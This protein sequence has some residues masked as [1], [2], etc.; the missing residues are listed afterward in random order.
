MS[1]RT[2]F[3]MVMFLT[4]VAGYFLLADFRRPAETEASTP[5]FYT[6]NMDD[7]RRIHFTASD[8]TSAGFFQDSK[9]GNWKFD[10]QY[11]MPVDLARW[12]GAT[13]LLSGPKS[14]R[15][16]SSTVEQPERFGLKSPV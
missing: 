11:A 6:A 12:G 14:H 3:V 16:L 7:I 8:G 15:A 13:L 2:T 9:D 10:D 1:I 4:V 5:W